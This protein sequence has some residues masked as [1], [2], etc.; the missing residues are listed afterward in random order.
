ML[1]F[2]RKLISGARKPMRGIESHNGLSAHIA[3]SSTYKTLEGVNRRFDLLWASSLTI[4]AS[5]NLPDQ[6][7]Y[8]FDGRLNTLQEI[9][10][11]SRLPVIFDGDTG[12]D[13]AGFSF[14]VNRVELL[15]ANGICIE[16]KVFPKRNSFSEAKQQLERLDIF[17]EKIAAGIAS[18]R[19]ADFKIIARVEALV[20]GCSLQEAVERACCYAAAGA[21]AILVQA[22]H[23]AQPLL[24]F[25]GRVR[26]ALQNT[27]SEIPIICAPTRFPHLTDEAF[28]SAGFDLII[29]ANH[30]LRAS[31][32]VMEHVCT[33]LLSG[34]GQQGV[35]PLLVP[36]SELLDFVSS[37]HSQAQ[38]P[39]RID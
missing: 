7:L 35:D 17:A 8:L 20:A 13:Q 4:S 21:D 16:D 19:S 31:F 3:S 32:R 25:P 38:L 22:K 34:E 29:Y 18:R 39:R 15:G 36:I 1:S 11:A 9:I 12:G 27:L 6:E 10:F 30:L 28:Y 14:L 37:T 5:K 24:E 26:A 23:E 2:N 33:K